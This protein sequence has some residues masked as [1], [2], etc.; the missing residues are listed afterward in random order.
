MYDYGWKPYVPV[1]KR[2]EKAEKAVAKAQRS[3]TTLAPVTAFRGAPAKTFWGKAW[4]DNL[5]RY[6]DIANRL[7]RGRSYVRNGA[8][9]DL[10]IGDG[11]VNAQVMGSR[12]YRV[13]VAIRHVADSQWKSIAADC[14]GSI[15]T[16]VELLEGK[17]S[18]AM[19]ERISQSGDGLF[20]VPKEIDF[21]CSCPDWASM[22]KHVAATLYGIGNRLDQQPELLFKLRGVDAAELISNAGSGL[23]IVPPVV[24]ASKVLDHSELADVFGIELAQYPTT[25]APAPAKTTRKPRQTKVAKTAVAPR[26][27]KS[28]A[29]VKS[30]RAFANKP[31]SKTTSKPTGKTIKPT[32]IAE[33]KASTTTKPRSTATTKTPARGRRKMVASATSR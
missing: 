20:P 17:L 9:I 29:T 12:L 33:P 4:C 24:D 10:Q 22:C 7:P 1:V 8:V 26:S 3:G 11:T 31:T 6:S 14:S 16:L 32:Q 21:Q 15:N 2:R 18:K 27:T 13:E 19:M 28:V 30:D 5:E 23:D 25:P